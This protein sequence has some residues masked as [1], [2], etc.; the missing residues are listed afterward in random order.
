MPSWVSSINPPFP[1]PIEALNFDQDTQGYCSVTLFFP[2]A[3]GGLS[4]VTANYTIRE[5]KYRSSIDLQ[6]DTYPPSDAE[7]LKYL[8]HDTLES[9][10]YNPVYKVIDI[11]WIESY[12]N[13]WL[14]KG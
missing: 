6:L 1:A 14:S 13:Y 12:S 9:F 8:A 2:K 10:G 7:G 5:G 4:Q 11:E 3:G